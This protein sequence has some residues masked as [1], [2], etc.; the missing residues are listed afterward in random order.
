M[1]VERRASFFLTTYRDVKATPFPERRGRPRKMHLTCQLYP[2]SANCQ[3]SPDDFCA[4][5]LPGGFPGDQCVATAVMIA[6]P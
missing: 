4:S 3:L 6:L 2:G 1:V 5:R